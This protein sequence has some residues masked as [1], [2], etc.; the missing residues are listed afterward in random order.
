MATEIVMQGGSIE[1]ADEET[2]NKARSRVNDALKMK[3]DFE[4]G[5][6]DGKTDGEKFQPMHLLSFD[7]ADGGRV[8]VNPEKIIAV[9]SDKPKD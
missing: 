7:T 4:N 3:I 9:L 8:S 5:N 6:I 2:F 1:L